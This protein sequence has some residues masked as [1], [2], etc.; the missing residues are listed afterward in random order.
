MHNA[1]LWRSATSNV[2]QATWYRFF[3]SRLRSGSRNTGHVQC[4]RINAPAA[5]SNQKSRHFVN[6][7]PRQKLCHKAEKS[8][9]EEQIH[10]FTPPPPKSMLMICSIS[11]EP[12]QTTLA[13]G[14]GGFQNISI[15][16]V[17]TVILLTDAETLGCDE[18]VWRG[19]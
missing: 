8:R 2:V 15:E 19:F 3:G 4:T 5:N 17:G 10:T 6:Y 9:S 16:A 11:L 12:R 13:L 14:N 7:N 18:G 1:P